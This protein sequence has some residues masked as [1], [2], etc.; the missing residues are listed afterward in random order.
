MSKKSDA[1]QARET[2]KAKKTEHNARFNRPDTDPDSPD[3]VAS[4]DAV[5]D[6]AQHVPW[7][8]R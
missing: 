7:W 2:Y 3:F 8:S 1:K 5:A 4:N 6:A